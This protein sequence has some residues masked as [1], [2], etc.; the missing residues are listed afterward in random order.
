M[1]VTDEEEVEHE[2]QYILTK[3]G[4]PVT[5]DCTDFTEN[6]Q[7]WT[8]AGQTHHI[9]VK[10]EKKEIPSNYPQ[11]LLKELL[12]ES[13]RGENPYFLLQQLCTSAM[14]VSGRLLG[15]SPSQELQSRLL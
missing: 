15:T 12:S 14:T 6:S 3:F 11:R 8:R 10:A 5:L 7:N 1:E 4:S 2:T 9:A 13:F